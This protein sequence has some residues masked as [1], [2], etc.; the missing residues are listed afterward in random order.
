MWPVRLQIQSTSS[1]NSNSLNW[2]T[3]GL[4]LP[5]LIIGYYLYINIVYQLAILVLVLVLARVIV[6]VI[7]IYLL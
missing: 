6:I 1:V 3:S 5:M 2:V 7:V 4:L